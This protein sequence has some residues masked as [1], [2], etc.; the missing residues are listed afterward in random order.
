M[1]EIILKERQLKENLAQVVNEC[2]LPAFI[3]KSDLKE[4]YEQIALLEQRQYQQAKIN[5]Q[6]KEE[7]DAKN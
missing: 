2:E 4:L 5:K 3:I 1:E 6:N 7:A